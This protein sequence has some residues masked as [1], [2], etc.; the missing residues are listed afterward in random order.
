MI[1]LSLHTGYPT[2]TNEATYKGYH[3]QNFSEY[4]W[5]ILVKFPPNWEPTTE[6]YTYAAMGNLS[7]EWVAIRLLD[8]IELTKVWFEPR[9]TP[10]KATYMEGPGD[11]VREPEAS[12]VHVRAQER[13]GE[14][15]RGGEGLHRSEP[16]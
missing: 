1:Q 11:A 16:R 10:L 14:D 3:R 15:R 4:P 2:Y 8:P 7:V 5:D 6:V 12:A 13:Q 9:V